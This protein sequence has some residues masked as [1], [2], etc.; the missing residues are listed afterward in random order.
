MKKK[1]IVLITWILFVFL[2]VC[3]FSTLLSNPNRS[4]E[5]QVKEQVEE[6][7]E[8][9]YSSD[10]ARIRATYRIITNGET[11]KTEFLHRGRWLFLDWGETLRE[12]QKAIDHAVQRKLKEERMA[13]QTWVPIE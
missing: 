5:E 3:L 1:L 9:P 7:V 6:Q 11:Y 8:E 13:A 12:N 2:L 4:K 10:E